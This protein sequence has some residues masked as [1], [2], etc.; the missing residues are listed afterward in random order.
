MIKNYIPAYYETITEYDIV[1][2]IDEFGGFSFPC[3]KDG[4]L[5]SNVPKEAKENYKNCLEHLEK[6]ERF[7]AKKKCKILHLILSEKGIITI[8]KKS[9]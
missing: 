8:I 7:K 9:T 3:D 4:N 6:F 1:F 5:L 2:D